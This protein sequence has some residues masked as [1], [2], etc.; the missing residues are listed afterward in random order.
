MRWLDQRGVIGELENTRKEDWN[1]AKT[2]PEMEMLLKHYLMTTQVD[3]AVL[4]P[5][6]V[7]DQD[8]I[9][10]HDDKMELFRENVLKVFEHFQKSEDERITFPP[11]NSPLRYEIH[12]R[13]NEFNF[14]SFSETGQN[15]LQQVTVTKTE[16]PESVAKSKKSVPSSYS[17][18]YSDLFKE[19]DENNLLKNEKSKMAFSDRISS[20][21]QKL[22]QEEINSI[23][24]PHMNT[25][26]RELVHTL[27]T[28]RGLISCSFCLGEDKFPVVFKHDSAPSMTSL[29][30]ISGCDEQSSIFP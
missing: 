25:E 20:C 21:F 24:F 26:L 22:R 28:K 5:V 29:K 3:T 4:F 13:C 17:I 23:A 12:I 1:L 16:L 15:P 14:R 27:A 19:L 8:E 18:G 30:A 10:S 11:L 9:V 2:S 6:G 7:E